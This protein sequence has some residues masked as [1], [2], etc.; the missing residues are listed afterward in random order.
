MHIPDD[1]GQRQ[2][3]QSPGRR[4]S[5]LPIG[6]CDTLRCP[7]QLRHF[8]YCQWCIGIRPHGPPLAQGAL[9]GKFAI[10]VRLR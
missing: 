7:Y 2:R 4:G 10:V 9:D 5:S 1:Q 3:I 6:V 8:G